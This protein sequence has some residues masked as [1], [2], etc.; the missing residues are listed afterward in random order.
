[1]EGIAGWIIFENAQLSLTIT[2]TENVIT[3]A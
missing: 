1:M 2:I 3:L